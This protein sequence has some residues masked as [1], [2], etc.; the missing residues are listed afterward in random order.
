MTINITS[1]KFDYPI[2]CFI[3]SEKH[4]IEPQ[5]IYSFNGDQISNIINFECDWTQ[6]QRAHFTID[7]QPP[8]ENTIRNRSTWSC[9]TTG[10][11]RVGVFIEYTD[12]PSKIRST[13]TIDSDDVYVGQ[14]PC[15]G[16][17]FLTDQSITF[18]QTKYQYP[19]WIYTN[20][21]GVQM[22]SF[23]QSITI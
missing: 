18:T 6:S 19:L 12:T 5:S 7:V 8:S 22:C 3:N 1:G 15:N 4:S 10:D 11:D 21:D 17:I 23:D 2:E 16:T 13:L 14:Q 20:D 9:A